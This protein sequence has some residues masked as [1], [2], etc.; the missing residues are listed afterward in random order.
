MKRSPQTADDELV[1]YRI[2]PI[3]AAC[4][5]GGKVRYLPGLLSGKLAVFEAA[6]LGL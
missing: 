3:L 2:E 1:G 6:V 5:V 4:S